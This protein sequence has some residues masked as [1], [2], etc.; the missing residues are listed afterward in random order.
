MF[1]L[2]IIEVPESHSGATL[3]CEFQAMLKCFHVQDKVSYSSE[4]FW[5]PTNSYPYQMLA[6]TGD[7]ATS[8]DMQTAE[9]EKKKNLFNLGNH[10]HC[11]NH[12]VQLSAKALLRPF[13]ICVSSA[14]TDNEVPLLKDV[15]D[16][17]DGDDGDGNDI[18]DVEDEDDPLAEDGN[19]IDD[20]VD[21]GVDELAELSEEE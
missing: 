13:T 7:N 19:N 5:P 12:T 11:F 1:L 6:F 20:D 17:G 8:N 2:D 4:F 14:T 3:A 9:L 15:E 18:E 16:D 21:D 10:V